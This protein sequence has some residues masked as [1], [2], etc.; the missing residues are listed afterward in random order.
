MNTRN[1]SLWFVLLGGGLFFG[2][3]Q[4]HGILRNAM[5]ANRRPSISYATRAQNIQAE[6]LTIASGSLDGRPRPT[7]WKTEWAGTFS[8]SGLCGYTLRFAPQSGITFEHW[9]CLGTYSENHGEITKAGLDGLTI[10]WAEKGMDDPFLA[11]Q[12]YFVRWGNLQYLIP[13]GNL[14][15]FIEQYNAGDRDLEATMF[16]GALKNF[17]ELKLDRDTFRNGPPGRP[18]LP[19]RYAHLLIDGKQ[20]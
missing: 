1:A 5:D 15:G 18:V 10:R 7:D 12:Y 11:T 3:V 9:G 13:E 8:T 16:I 14:L 2:F 4:L 20:Q 19:A 17:G 6:L